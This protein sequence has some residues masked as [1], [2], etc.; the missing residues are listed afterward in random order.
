MKKD[1]CILSIFILS[2]LNLIITIFLFGNMMIFCDEYNSTPALVCGGNFGLFLSWF[3]LVLS[4]LLCI[5]AYRNIS[6]QE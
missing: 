5:F 2:I 1:A 6:K 3:R 4:L